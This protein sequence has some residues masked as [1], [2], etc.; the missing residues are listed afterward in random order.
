[1][2]QSAW[3]LTGSGDHLTRIPT[4]RAVGIARGLSLEETARRAGMDPAHLSRVERGERQPSVDALARLA[5]ALGLVEMARPLA[6]YRG[7]L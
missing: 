5:E 3:A 4:L 2:T 7:V 6:P 1:M